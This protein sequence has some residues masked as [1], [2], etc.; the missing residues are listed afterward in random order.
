MFGRMRMKTFPNMSMAEFIRWSA[1]RGIRRIRPLYN[2]TYRKEEVKKRL[3]ADYGWQWYGGHHLENRTAAF[4]HLY[5][6]P[7]R[8]N[9]DMRHLGHAALVR[10]GQLSRDE[11]LEILAQPV[12]CPEDIVLL[13]KKRLGFTDAEFE[14]V[15]SLPK[16]TWQEFPNYKRTFERLRPL[17]AVMVKTG[18]V[19][20]SFYMKFC[21]PN[22]LGEKGERP[23]EAA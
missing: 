10:S 21:F 6:L 22:E 7:R 11:A 13:V 16:R 15:M 1:L 20:Q 9:A 19:P 8:W 14:R 2:M 12:E 23:A 4:W 18:R 5:V 17:F 3:A